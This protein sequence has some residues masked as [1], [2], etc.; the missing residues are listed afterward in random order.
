MSASATERSAPRKR[1]VRRLAENIAVNQ[2]PAS[3]MHAFMAEAT[4]TGHRG[5]I[6]DP[7]NNRVGIG[8]RR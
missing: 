3:T 1:F 2:Y 8:A 6:L 4:C 5:N 7:R